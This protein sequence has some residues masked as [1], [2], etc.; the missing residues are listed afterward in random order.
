VSDPQRMVENIRN[1]LYASQQAVDLAAVQAQASGYAEACDEVNRRLARCEE[2]LRQGLRGEAIQYAQT[3]PAV[4]EVLTI[5]D[6][7]ERP[8]WEQ[9]LTACELPLPPVFNTETATALN[10]AYTEAQPLEHLLRRHRALALGRAPLGQRLMVLHQLAELDPHNPVWP[11]DIATFEAERLRQL[12]RE[13]DTLGKARDLPPLERV[14]ELVQEVQGWRSG[15]PAGLSD[16][17]QSLYQ[18]VVSGHW[19]KH[20]NELADD[21]EAAYQSKDEHRARE[22]AAQW[23]QSVGQRPV[24]AD[25]PRCRRIDRVLRWL[26]KKEQKL[27]EAGAHQQ[28]LEQLRQALRDR[29]MGDDDLEEYYQQA[30][31]FP[32]GVPADLENAY[33]RRIRQ[34]RQATQRWERLILSAV[35]LVVVLLIVV[36]VVL[37]RLL[38]RLR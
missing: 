22:L 34:I 36:V 9:L 26:E 24:S 1:L 28:A 30:A 29:N 27:E 7:R 19:D 23:A 14:Q 35:A 10:R 2:F 11:Q 13:I 6:F 31:E 21:L 3:E 4:L 18:D 17:I 38:P 15:L 33:H 8:H 5:L 25:D 12:E 20:L 16:A 37:A 32:A